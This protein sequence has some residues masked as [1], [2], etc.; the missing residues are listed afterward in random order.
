MEGVQQTTRVCSYDRF[1]IGWSSGNGKPTSA[2]EIAKTL[3]TLLV[4]AD[5]NGPVIL[6]GF[7]AGGIYV[8]KYIDIYPDQ[9]VGLV[10]VDSAHEQQVAR[11]AY[12][13]N[14]TQ[15]VRIC[16][17]LSWTGLIRFLGLMDSDVPKTFSAERAMQ[18]RSVY[19]R[20]SFCSGLLEQSA[21]FPSEFTG[22][23]PRPLGELPLIVIKSDKTLREQGF[24]NMFPDEFLDSHSNVWPV[25]QKELAALSSDSEFWTAHGSGHSIPVE[26]AD[27]VVNAILK[28]LDKVRTT[29]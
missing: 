12:A 9:I 10:L 29:N 21:G 26:Q 14:D 5:I 7:S 3:N 18:Q 2:E 23:P 11:N 8:R 16:S 6:V 25:L 1:G 15:L 17:A 27:I 20:T 4:K 19:Y 24:G 28:L 22:E 13:P